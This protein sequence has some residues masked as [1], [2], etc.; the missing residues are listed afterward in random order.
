MEMFT[1]L[2]DSLSLKHVGICHEILWEDTNTAYNYCVELQYIFKNNQVN[3]E[4]HL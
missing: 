2:H 4:M 1:L 3:V